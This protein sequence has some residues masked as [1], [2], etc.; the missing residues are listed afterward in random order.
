MTIRK[1]SLPEVHRT[2]AIPNTTNFWRKMAAYTGSGYLVSVG[3]MDPGNWATDIAGG[4][5]FG[6]A[7]L[8]VILGANLMAM[9]LQS[10]CVRLGVATG[11]D[12]AQLC[13]DRFSPRVSF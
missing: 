9:L 3:H 11:R 5:K 13:R 6:N 2:I 12:L 8:S 4:S 10:L 7:L 1:P